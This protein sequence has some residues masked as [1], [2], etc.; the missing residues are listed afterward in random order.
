MYYFAMSVKALHI[1][2]MVSWFAALFYLPRLFVY[3][4]MSEDPIS[5]KRFQV[6]ERKLY[7]GIA[8]PAMLATILLG[9]GMVMFNAAYYVSQTWFWLKISLV[10]VLIGYHH[11]CGTYVKKFAAELPVPG[12]KFF[13]VFNEIPVFFLLAIV[14]LVVLKLPS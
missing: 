13:R 8:T 4:A 3:H 2:A 12:H 14:F 9:V 11:V 6:M 5:R 7:L 1:V 10:V